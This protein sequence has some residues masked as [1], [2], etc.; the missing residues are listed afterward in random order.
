MTV[1]LLAAQGKEERHGDLAL[2]QSPLRR[3]FGLTPPASG[4]A[5]SF[6]KGLTLSPFR[7][8]RQ[9]LADG[10]GISLW[11]SDSDKGNTLGHTS[12][13]YVRA[14]GWFKH[15]HV[16]V[17]RYGPYFVTTSAKLAA[18]LPR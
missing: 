9:R 17:Y 13:S 1:C 18:S 14:T 7:C 8:T 5:I 10:S 11:V 2:C 3:E 4:Y 6:N 16:A 15:P 12:V